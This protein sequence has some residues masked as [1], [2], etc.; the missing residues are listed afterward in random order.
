[1]DTR[2]KQT[3]KVPIFLK[4]APDLSDE[5]VKSICKSVTVKGCKVDGLIVSNT[6]IS[7]SSL[8]SIESLQSETGGLSGKPLGKMSTQLIEKFYKELKGSLLDISW[9]TN[10]EL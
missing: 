9:N 5:D 3:K 8:K 4:V 10:Y 1:M 6:T 7:R 2:D